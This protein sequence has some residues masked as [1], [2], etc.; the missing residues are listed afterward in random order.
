MAVDRTVGA[1]YADRIITMYVQ[2]EMQ[3]AE[4]IARGVKSNVARDDLSQ[5]LL[6]LSEV[7]RS[8]EA[9]LRKIDGKLAPAVRAALHDAAVAGGRAAQV[10]MLKI[11]DKRAVGR[12]VT[13]LDRNLVNNPSL[14][15]LAAAL[16]PA[17]ES[18]LRAT[19]LQVVRSVGDIYQHAV[20]AMAAPGVLAGV[21]TRRE[22]SQVALD[23]LWQKG[24]TGFVDKAGRNWNL[25]SYVEMATRTATAQA[26]VQAHLDELAQSDINLV[27]V[28]ADGAPC[29]VCRPWEGKVLTTGSSAGAQHISRPSE[30]D[31][32]DTAVHVA[33]SV[34]EATGAGLFHPS[35]RHTLVAFLPGLTTPASTAG[36]GADVYR[37]EQQ[38]RRMEREARRIAVAQAGAV[39]PARQR[40]LA[41]QYRAKRAE[42]AQHVKDNPRLRRKTERE[43]IDLGHTPSAPRP[44]APTPVPKQPAPPKPKPEPTPPP[45]PA[46][47]PEPKPEV[48]V[49]PK[50]APAPVPKVS[51]MLGRVTGGDQARRER[52]ANTLDEQAKIVPKTIEKLAGVVIQSNRELMDDYGPEA[53]SGMAGFYR[54]GEN[55]VHVVDESFS[56]DYDRNCQELHRNGWFAHSDARASEYLLSHET[57]HHVD[58][59]LRDAPYAKR[60]ELWQ[61]IADRFGLPRPEGAQGVDLRDW[62]EEYKSHIE[63]KVSRYGAYSRFEI[64][65]EMWAEYTTSSSPRPY[66]KE[67]GDKIREI[68]EG[69]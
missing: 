58:A 3:L 59:V 25:A 30:L 26:S 28:S 31:G 61:L 10:D 16:S 19:H 33:G 17:L 49:K 24:I 52:A 21:T 11:R 41:A 1:Q 68:V 13:Q 55:K 44:P 36:E 27:M 50:P 45:R 65:A 54:A 69:I 14:L 42:I 64:M 51:P 40:E 32:T 39:D 56:V 63:S 38:Q 67:I 12:R 46:P 48:Q 60:L 8:A 66:I 53:P 34:S 57:G 9:A 15:R 6:A 47:K 35:C 18:R 20:A 2:L 62:V 37:A 7:R 29:P 22:A 5:K 43:R 23:H 4:I